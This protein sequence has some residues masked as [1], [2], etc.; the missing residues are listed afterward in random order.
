MSPLPRIRLFVDAD[1][2]PK[3]ELGLTPEQSHYL[4]KVMRLGTGDG[5]MVFNGRDGEFE[6]HISHIAK[7][8]A[9]LRIQIQTRPQKGVPDIWLL[10]APVKRLRIDFLAQKSTELGVSVLQ[11][12][13]TQRTSVARVNQDR[14]LSNAIEAAE[15][16]ERLCVPEIR[17]LKKLDSILADWNESR[18]L[19]FCDEDDAASERPPLGEVLAGSDAGLWAILVGPEGGFTDDEA[20]MLRA[21]PY[22][23]PVSL[24]PRI[25]RADTAALAA[26]A[27]WQSHLGDW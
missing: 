8:S 18:S 14:L 17:P 3:A 19:I 9:T 25:L 20:D 13:M 21:L 12:V 2:A 16:T 26:L 11:P 15:Q 24:G 27:L 10:F 6:A 22:T 5:L 1:L 7:R 4:T 23:L